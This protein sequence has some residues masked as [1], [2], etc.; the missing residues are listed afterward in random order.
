MSNATTIVGFENQAGVT[1]H[2]FENK[3]L[4]FKVLRPG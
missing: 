4:D 1:V 2:L 3:R